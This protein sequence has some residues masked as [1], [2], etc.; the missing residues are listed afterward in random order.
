[1]ALIADSDRITSKLSKQTIVDTKVSVK[2]IDL[3][4]FY[5]FAATESRKLSLEGNTV[6]I[7]ISGQAIQTIL[8]PAKS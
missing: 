6:D 2:E 5:L 3:E 4:D 8:I 1:M 7:Q